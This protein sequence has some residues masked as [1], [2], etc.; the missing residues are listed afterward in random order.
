MAPLIRLSPKKNPVWCELG[1]SGIYTSRVTADFVRKEP[2]FRY[3]GNNRR[4]RKNLNSTVKSA[5]PEK[6]LFSANSASLAFVQAEL[7][8]ICVENGRNFEIQ[9]LKEYLTDLHQTS[10]R[11]G[12]LNTC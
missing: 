1:G 4:S 5:V 12:P 8:P 7:W 6:P 9:Y 3:H 10:I 11:T 2:H